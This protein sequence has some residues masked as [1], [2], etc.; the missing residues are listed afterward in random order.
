MKTGIV[1][2]SELKKYGRWDAEFNLIQI[3]YADRARAIS[4][5]MSEDEVVALLCDE[6]S[7]PTKVL[8]HL[9]PLTRGSKPSVSREQLLRAVKEYPF[10]SLAIV[11]DRGAAA[12]EALKLEMTQ[13]VQKMNVAQTMLADAGPNIP[14]L[15]PLPLAQRAQVNLSRY[16]AGVVYYDGDELSIPVETSD[17][18]YVADCWVIPLSEWAGPATIDALVQDGNVPVP[19]QYQ[20]LG[21][22]VGF[23]DALADHTVNYDGG[24]AMQPHRP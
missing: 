17:T 11:K 4:V 1:M 7:I 9:L 15:L 13:Q 18:A 2:M 6:K 5:T 20:D 10:L 16:V 19:R 12:L 24:W 21:Q 8:N 23:V 14:N 22:V 3:E